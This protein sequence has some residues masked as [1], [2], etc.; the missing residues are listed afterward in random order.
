MPSSPSSHGDAS[1]SA[2]SSL[3]IR[4]P[5]RR[6]VALSCAECR[7]CVRVLNAIYIRALTRP[8]TSLPTQ[9][10]AQVSLIQCIPHVYRFTVYQVQPCI[11]LQVC[12]SRRAR[13][14]ALLLGADHDVDP[15]AAIASKKVVQPSVL[16]VCVVPLPAAFPPSAIT[17]T[18][19]CL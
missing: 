18:Y 13:R 16:K 19:F 4:Q 3:V 7:R 2:S 8:R 12:I 6:G 11:S 9:T 10:Q 5:K 1:P 14:C 15:M 17:L